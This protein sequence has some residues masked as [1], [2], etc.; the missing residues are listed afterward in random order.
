MKVVITGGTGQV[1]TILA[2]ALHAAG[3]EVVILSRRPTGAAWRIVPWDARS[4]GPWA[5]ELEE[6]DAVINLAGRS[7]NCRYS[8]ANRW[9]IIESRVQS[10]RAVGAAIAQA[11]NPPRVWLQ[12]STATI[13]SHRYDAANDE[14][15][16]IIGGTEEG[17][18]DTW[19][20]SIDVAKAWEAAADEHETPATRKVLLRTA[21][22]MSPD[23]GG[24]F[25][26]LLRLVR[27]GL[28]GAAAGGRQYVSWIHHA[29][30]VRAMLWLIDHV[31]MEGAVN[32]AAPHPL[33]NRAFMDALRTAWGASVGLPA[34]SWMLEVGAFAMRTETE[35]VLKSRRVVPGRLVN[36]GFEFEYPEWSAAAR[37]LCQEWRT[38]SNGL[39]LR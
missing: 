9:G 1:G 10:T 21:M 19:R 22:V 36:A 3:H 25:D 39:Q 32:L 23:R 34:T 35:L 13:Y 28:G 2:R 4:I 33:P 11:R 12:M 38:H 31:E 29:D 6:A 8:S 37:I 7:V 14:A 18:P 20:F 30:F 27:V 16:G 5:V 26:T 15:S 24:V 17:A